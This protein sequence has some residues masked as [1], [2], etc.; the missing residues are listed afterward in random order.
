MAR[1]FGL[2][3]ECFSGLSTVPFFTTGDSDCIGDGKAIP[4]LTELQ[5][6]SVGS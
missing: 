4:Y 6:D 5:Q 3:V 2:A 1:V